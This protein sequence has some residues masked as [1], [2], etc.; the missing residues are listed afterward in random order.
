MEAASP[1]FSPAQGVV[2]VQTSVPGTVSSLPLSPPTSP[3][4]QQMPPK[5]TTPTSPPAVVSSS[6]QGQGH[7]NLTGSQAPAENGPRMVLTEVT[8]I[9]GPPTSL[10]S[11]VVPP[12][13]P[14]EESMY[15]LDKTN[16]WEDFNS[17][18]EKRGKNTRKNMYRSVPLLRAGRDAQIQT[19]I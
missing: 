13:S 12:G 8:N 5:F 4:T 9:N 11:S 10:Q 1:P 17:D 14:H 2:T 16:K 19:A 15:H 18:E 6:L 7:I 3:Q